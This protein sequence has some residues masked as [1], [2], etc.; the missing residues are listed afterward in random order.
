MNDAI[1]MKFNLIND[2]EYSVIAIQEA[3]ISIKNA[4]VRLGSGIGNIS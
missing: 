2:W 3:I 4:S 1:K